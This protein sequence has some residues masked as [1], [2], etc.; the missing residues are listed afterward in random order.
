MNPSIF[1]KKLNCNGCPAQPFLD[2]DRS[3]LV[4]TIRLKALKE[5]GGSPRVLILCESA[6]SGRFV[7]DRSSDYESGGLRANLREELT[8]DGKDE[9]LFQYLKEKKVW[10]VDAALCALHK[11]RIL[12]NAQR[13][14]AATIC[15]S[16]H[17]RVYLD[18]FSDAPV[19][20]IFPSNCGILKTT[21]YDIARRIRQNFSFGSLG[22]LKQTIEELAS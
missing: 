3:K 2:I 7:Y 5:I 11:S 10:I 14:N 18:S 9:S 13:R 6:P 21:L 15:M 12:T 19:V 4:E 20:S 1:S 16:R 8:S 17:T 22:G